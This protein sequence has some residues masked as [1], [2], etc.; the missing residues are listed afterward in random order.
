MNEGKVTNVDR[1]IEGILVTFADGFTFLF[2]SDF[3]YKVRLKDGQ[4]VGR[5]KAE[6]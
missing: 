5:E 4:L 1:T 2:Q 6:H 3:L